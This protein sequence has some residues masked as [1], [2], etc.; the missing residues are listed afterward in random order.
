LEV[1]GFEG[2]GV[3]GRLSWTLGKVVPARGVL[4]SRGTSETA[5]METVGAG[6][7]KEVYFKAT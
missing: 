4:S 1:S 5:Q 2:D 6:K 7:N 3:A